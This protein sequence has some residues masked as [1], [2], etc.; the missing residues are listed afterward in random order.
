MTTIMLERAENDSSSASSPRKRHAREAEE[1]WAA[2]VRREAA[3]FP[4]QIGPRSA[5]RLAQLLGP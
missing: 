4:T 1:K 5:A 2:A 3:K